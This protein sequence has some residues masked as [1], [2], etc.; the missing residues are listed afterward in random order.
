MASR[1]HWFLQVVV[2]TVARGGSSSS[3]STSFPLGS[4]TGVC[5]SFSFP[6]DALY[7]FFLLLHFAYGVCGGHFL[8]TSTKSARS[9]P[10]VGSVPFFSAPTALT[11]AAATE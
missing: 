4:L 8:F 11:V 7:L 3:T 10:F 6:E 5:P 2:A 9:L 1:R